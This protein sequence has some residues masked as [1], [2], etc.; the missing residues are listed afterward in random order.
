[1]IINIFYEIFSVNLWEKCY[2][3]LQFTFIS[4]ENVT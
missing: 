2:Y 3:H 1:M 4:Y